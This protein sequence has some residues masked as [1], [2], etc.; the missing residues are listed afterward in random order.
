[1]FLYKPL[2]IRF[3][4]N[5]WWTDH[6]PSFFMVFRDGNISMLAWVALHS[7]VLLCPPAQGV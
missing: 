4:N 6:G 1:M 7:P 2:D 5:G 3:V